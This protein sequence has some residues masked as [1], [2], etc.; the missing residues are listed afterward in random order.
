MQL[1]AVNAAQEDDTDLEIEIIKATEYILIISCKR[2][3]IAPNK[4]QKGLKIM[5]HMLPFYSKVMT[6]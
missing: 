3:Q 1:F 2:K 6:I 4:H 5:I